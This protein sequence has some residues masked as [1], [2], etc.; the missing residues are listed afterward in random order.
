MAIFEPKKAILEA[1]MEPGQIIRGLLREN[2]GMAE[3]CSEARIRRVQ[4]EYRKVPYAGHP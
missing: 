4:L 1:K 2:G 3:T